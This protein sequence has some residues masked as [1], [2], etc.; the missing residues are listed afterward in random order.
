MLLTVRRTAAAPT[1]SR[2]AL[3]LVCVAQLLVVADLTAV[4]MA[5][6]SIGA[7][8]L[9]GPA[10]LPWVLAAYPLAFGSLVLPASRLPGFLAGAALFTV[11]SAVAGLASSGELLVSARLAQ[12]FGAALVSGAALAMVAA[13]GGTGRHRVLRWWLALDA[14]AAVLGVLVGGVAVSWFGWRAVF[15]AAAA[16]GLLILPLARPTPRVQRSEPASP[17]FRTRESNAQNPRVPHSGS[18]SPLFGGGLAGRERGTRGVGEWRGA[19]AMGAAVVL[20]VHGSVAAGS[21]SLVAGVAAVVLGA[22]CVAVFVLVEPPVTPFMAHRSVWS[23]LVVL[24]GAV[25]LLVA[26]FVGSSVRLQ[27]AGLSPPRAALLLLPAAVAALAVLPVAGRLTRLVGRRTM[28]HLGFASAALGFWMLTEGLVAAG[29]AVVAVCL[30]PMVVVGAG[31]ATSRVAQRDAGQVTGLLAGYLQL[32]TVLGVALAGQ[33]TVDGA[34]L[35][36]ILVA[37]VLAVVPM[38]LLPKR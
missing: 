38:A 22:A 28:S 8:L 34:G 3:V 31:S 21:G 18:A 14:V 25:G 35:T 27:L 37:G 32:G 9:L 10:V 29:L 7:D 17:T 2:S 23:G 36:A 33:A 11:A 6:P 15:F 26:A 5:L 20:L 30:A 16:V 12:G 4:T 1:L 19:A 24:V 13:S